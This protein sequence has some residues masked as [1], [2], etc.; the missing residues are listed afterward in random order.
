MD[1]HEFKLVHILSARG[2]TIGLLPNGDPCC[3]AKLDGEICAL[4]ASDDIHMPSVEA[5]TSSEA[6]EILPCPFCN[7]AVTV[8]RR[9]RL[10]NERAPGPHYVYGIECDPCDLRMEEWNDRWTSGTLGDE[11][12]D[13]LNAKAKLLQR[14]NTRIALSLK[15]ENERL[16]AVIGLAADYIDPTTSPHRM[17][18]SDMAAMLRCAALEKKG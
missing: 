11:T 2:M 7:S 10:D 6:P 12:D 17:S 5:S 8:E 18:G 15:A 1:K 3:G 14:W 13:D 16:Q 9:T 4:P